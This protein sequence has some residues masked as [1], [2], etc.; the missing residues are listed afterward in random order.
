M[1]TFDVYNQVSIPLVDIFIVSL[2][3]ALFILRG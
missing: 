2:A 3:E 1:E